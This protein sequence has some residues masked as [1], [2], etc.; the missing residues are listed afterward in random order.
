M[1]FRCLVNILG[2]LLYLLKG[3]TTLQDW[4]VIPKQKK[5]SPQVSND[6]FVEI[7]L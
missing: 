6:G 4:A 7:K 2:S 5:V 1:Y 3:S